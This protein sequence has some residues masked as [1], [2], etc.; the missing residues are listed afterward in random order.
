M[1]YFNI[2][3]E[4]E[5]IKK[6]L[7][8]CV[9]FSSR[10]FIREKQQI[11]MI[12]LKSMIDQQL[13]SNAIFMPLQT[14][15]GKFDFDLLQS[16]IIKCA[17]VKTIKKEEMILNI[18]EGKVILIT[19]FSRKIL[20]ID[21]LKFPTRTP[22]EPPTSPVLQGPREGFVEDL[23]TNITLLRRRIKSEKLVIEVVRVGSQ[24]QTKVCISYIKGIASQKVIEK[25]KDKLSK[26]KIDGV[27]DSYNIL[28]FLEERP[29]SLFKQI[30]NQEKPDVVVAKMLEGKVALIV[31]NSPIILTIPFLFM[32]D[33][34]NSNDYYTNHHYSSMVRIIRL[35][36]LLLAIIA[37][38]FYLSLQIYHYNIL[39]LNFLVTIA[40]TTQGLPFTPFLEILFIFLLFQILYEVSLRLPSYLGLATSV[41]GALILGDTGVKAGLISPPGVII[42]ALSKIALYT[43]PE[44]SAQI[45]VLQLVFLFIG[46]SL[47]L[48]GLTSGAIYIINYLNTLDSFGTPYLAPYAPRIS[49]DLKDGLI[50]KSI[51]R[52][53]SRPKSFNPEKKE[54]S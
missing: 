10:V 31:D 19:N 53:N 20:S 49:S 41:V 28:S 15:N 52:M 30:G 42:V 21:L 9:D 32:E 35:L 40:D 33:L 8:N 27:V 16:N 11:G 18:L 37:P 14:F 46:G 36:G 24:T 34:Q 26:I 2:S 43:I 50:V 51:Q 45:T 25:I 39:P 3:K 38:G 6:T 17:D 23:Q 44:Q 7:N 48:V 47:G 54:R 13:L 5:D 29:N 1:S 22:S 4:I 12:F